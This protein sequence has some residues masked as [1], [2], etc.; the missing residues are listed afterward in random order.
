MKVDSLFAARVAERA[1]QIVC[2]GC[3]HGTFEEPDWVIQP[4]VDAQ[5]AMRRAGSDVWGGQGWWRLHT[6]QATMCL[7][8]L[9]WSICSDLDGCDLEIESS[10]RWAELDADETVLMLLF[11]AQA[12]RAKRARIAAKKRA[13]ELPSPALDTA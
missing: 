1:A 5:T 11:V 8:A 7:Q 12:I 10:R 13:A 4:G 3:E 6:H 9:R 2:D